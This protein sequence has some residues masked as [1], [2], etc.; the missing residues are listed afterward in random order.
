MLV[1]PI[2]VSF[3]LLLLLNV[4]LTLLKSKSQLCH[5]ICRR[6]THESWERKTITQ[7]VCESK[8]VIM[9]TNGCSKLSVG[10]RAANVGG[11]T[12][13]DRRCSMAESALN[14]FCPNS[15]RDYERL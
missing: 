1:C 7:S 14:S 13:P 15:R 3:L 2:T 4:L 12:I 6:V 9:S 8:S 5:S 11:Q 10:V